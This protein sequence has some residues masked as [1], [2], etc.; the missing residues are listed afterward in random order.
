MT[1][2]GL[3]WVHASISNDVAVALRVQ[4][5]S[6]QVAAEA[7]ASADDEKDPEW[8]EAAGQTEP[9]T[10]RLASL[11]RDSA[12][13]LGLFKSLLQ[14][15]DDAKASEVHFVW[16]WRVFGR[17]SLMSPEMARWQGP[18]LWVHN[19]RSFSPQDFENITQLGAVKNTR[20]EQI[21]RF[22]LGFNSVYSLTDLPSILSDDVVLFLDPH[23][24]HLKAM[25]ASPAKP[26]IKL[27]FLRIDVL[28]KF[29]DQFEPYHGMFGCDLASSSPYEGTL[30]RL[31]F[32][33]AE[34]A[35]AS[36]ISKSVM[37]AELA[38]QLVASFRDA[39]AE[40]LIFLQHVRRIHFSWQDGESL[41]SLMEVKIVDPGIPCSIPFGSRP[42][43]QVSTAEHAYE[44]RRLFSSRSVAA[45]KEKQSFISDLLNRL[46]MAK[47]EEPKAYISFN[48]V[49]SVAWSPPPDLS[50]TGPYQRM[51]AWRL[52]LQHD[53]PE[54]ARWANGTDTVP[55]AGL[56]LC[57]SRP[58][59]KE[60]PRISCFLPLPIASSLPFLI[61]ANFALSDPTSSRR[62]DLSRNTSTS[63]WNQ[64]LLR[65][66][67]EPLICTLIR[68]QAVAIQAR[69]LT[70]VDSVCTL[71][72][73]NSQLP[74]SLQE[75]LNLPSI[76][77]ELSG[78]KLFPVM[79]RRGSGLLSYMDSVQ[80]LAEDVEERA[81]V[82]E[83]LSHYYSFCDVVGD[84]A[85][86]F[87]TAGVKRKALADRSL[88]LSCLQEHPL[89]NSEMAKQLLSFILRG[90]QEQLSKLKGLKLAPLCDGH[91]ASFQGIYCAVGSDRSPLAQRV[92]KQLLPKET[93]DLT[94]LDV[95][96]IRE[97]ADGL[98]LRIVESC[99]AC[100]EADLDDMTYQ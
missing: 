15:A 20:K 97:N 41:R 99:E 61:N 9:L 53:N 91:V 50:T 86:G 34:A 93:L 54:D 29:R 64:L 98:E 92:L 21:G 8:F 68:E 43:V 42:E 18:C 90:D 82:H 2:S 69:N 30:I 66:I 36:Q 10:T 27:R 23:V 62:L 75:L 25:G 48:L 46:G 6:T 22:G 77:K 16:D 100:L 47:S 45:S 35:K 85:V 4:A 78:S 31:P 94:G 19:N 67:I 1:A 89:S 11:L 7:L 55:F 88:V 70:F 40:C 76:Y 65:N 56:A 59:Q 73:R 14:N 81:A 38:A 24:H 80:P 87:S 17:Q 57:L 13:D 72:P 79:F 52:M 3:L 33:T 5:L 63:D 95:Q 26:G 32:R 44:Y 83:Y 39:A 96:K 12:E 71:M 58:L 37:S 74:A 84:V 28:D 51:E 60:E 49:V